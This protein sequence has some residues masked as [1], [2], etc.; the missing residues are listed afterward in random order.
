LDV[1]LTLRAGEEVLA[2]RSKSDKLKPGTE[3]NL[4]IKE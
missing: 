1:F 4:A 3:V 2:L